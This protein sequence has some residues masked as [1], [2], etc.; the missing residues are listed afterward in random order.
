M[1]RVRRGAGGVDELPAGYA[2]HHSEVYGDD[3][4][5]LCKPG[6]ADDVCSRD[7]VATVVLANGTTE[8]ERHEVADDPPVDCFYVYPTT[9]FDQGASS[10][11]TPGESEEIS[12]AYNQVARL[13]STCRVFAP[14]Y[15][16]ATISAIGGGSSAQDGLTPAPWPTATCS[17]R[18]ATTSPT[19]ATGEGS[20]WLGTPRG[21]ACSTG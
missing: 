4:H 16:Q 8:V 11:F 20:C 15:R 14:I 21:L 12:T 1:R 10:D 2:D 3:P 7:L 19:R 17:M 6:I 13:T 5:W 18:S 9:S